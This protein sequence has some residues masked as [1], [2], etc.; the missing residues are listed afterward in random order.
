MTY[1]DEPLAEENWLKR[2]EAENDENKRLEQKL[3]KRLDGTVFADTVV[4]F[5]S[6]LDRPAY[7]SISL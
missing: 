2:Y 3:H 6:K 7:K 4:C 1:T 5:V